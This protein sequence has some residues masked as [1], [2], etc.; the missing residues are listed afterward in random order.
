M[1]RLTGELTKLRAA[2]SFPLRAEGSYTEAQRCGTIQQPQ[3]QDCLGCR[4]GGV[5]VSCPRGFLPRRQGRAASGPGRKVSPL[6]FCAFHPSFLVFPSSLGSEES[7]QAGR[8][9]GIQR[10][11]GWALI[12]PWG[13]EG[14]PAVG[15]VGHIQPG[16][17]LTTDLRAGPIPCSLPTVI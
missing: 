6:P 3:P 12:R 10:D 2:P 1:A 8:E 15:R 4:L 13:G 16:T 17:A 7:G 5:Q 11:L 9:R 14:S